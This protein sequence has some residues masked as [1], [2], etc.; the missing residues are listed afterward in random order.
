[1]LKLCTLME[2]GCCILATTFWLDVLP[3]G[4]GGNGKGMK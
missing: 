2:A 1:M 3:E 4:F